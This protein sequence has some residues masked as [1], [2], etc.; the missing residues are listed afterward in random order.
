MAGTFIDGTLFCIT[1]RDPQITVFDK[2]FDLDTQPYHILLAIGNDITPNS[3]SEH[4]QRAASQT[5]VLL[6][7][8]AILGAAGVPILVQLHGAFMIVAW[9]GCCSIAIVL[10]RYFKQTWLSTEFM[11]KDYWFM[12]CFN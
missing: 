9:L 3:I 12:V 1:E 6:S 2:E 11:G 4:T 7:D 10:A 8:I 5:A